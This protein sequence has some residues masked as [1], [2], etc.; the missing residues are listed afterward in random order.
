MGL[1]FWLAALCGAVVLS[2]VVSP[3]AQQG[4]GAQPG[5]TW[6]DAKLKETI[7][8]ARV[9]RKLTPKA[10]PN[11]AKVAVCVSFDTDT[12]APLLR[13]GTTS[14]TALSASDF[15][16]P[17]R[18]AAHSLDARSAA[19][20]GDVFHDGRGCDAASGNGRG[21]SEIRPSRNRRARLD[22]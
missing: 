18:H 6:T 5:T 14:P 20:S 9:G 10:W 19:G 8:L 2:T 16:A 13:D 21:D 12:E 22:P 7:D 4:G 15:G 1:A 11:G 17:K 3:M